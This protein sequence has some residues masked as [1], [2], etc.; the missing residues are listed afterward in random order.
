MDNND[1]LRRLR[2]ALNIGDEGI[3][4]IYGLAGHNLDMASL[5][6]LLKKKDDEG[7]LPC[8]DKMLEYFLDGLIILKRGRKTD[9]PPPHPVPLSN[10]QVLRKLKIALQLKEPDILAIMKLGEFSFSKSELSA[11]FRSPSHPNYKPCGNQV[12]RY[13]LKGLTVKNRGV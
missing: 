12:L 7:S 8:S 1:I 5:P 11:L 9:T 10:N 2:F 6:G 3:K 13:F 4:E